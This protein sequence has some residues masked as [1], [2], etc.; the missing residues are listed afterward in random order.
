[1]SGNLVQV[2]SDNRVRVKDNKVVVAGASDPCCCTTPCCTCAQCQSKDCYQIKSYSSSIFDLVTCTNPAGGTEWDGKF[3]GGTNQFC[4]YT[5]GWIIIGGVWTSA[6]G[7]TYLSGPRPE[8]GWSCWRIRIGGT[9]PGL[10]VGDASADRIG[11]LGVYNRVSGCS[12]IPSTLEIEECSG[13]T[14]ITVPT[15]YRIASY[16]DG[17]LTACSGCS[18]NGGTAWNGHF[19]SYAACVWTAANGS[20]IN[21]KTFS[22]AS[23]KIEFDSVNCIW[24]VTVACNSDT[25]WYGTKAAHGVLGSTPA[26]VYTRVSGCD[27]TTTL[28]VEQCP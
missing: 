15:C 3:T 22:Q 10:W 12:S 5:T 26:G 17:D 27:S 18:A 20:A 4:L 2:G 19:E 11:P 14:A 24:K 25:V 9:V 13:A 16:S 21:A 6:V 7:A 1:M 8:L 23:T 28:T